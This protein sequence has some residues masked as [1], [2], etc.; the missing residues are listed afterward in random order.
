MATN[1][2]GKIVLITCVG[3]VIGAAIALRLANDGA[4]IA[5]LDIKDSKV[6]A[7]ADEVRAVDRRALTFKADVSKR[8]DGLRRV[9]PIMMDNNPNYHEIGIITGSTRPGCVGESV[10]R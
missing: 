10:R 3:Q 7:A 5:V 4:D 9:L 2:R 6:K 8:D 1:I